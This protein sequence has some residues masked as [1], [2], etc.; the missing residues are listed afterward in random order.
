MNL[1]L[2]ILAVGG[3]IALAIFL[4]NTIADTIDNVK[5]WLE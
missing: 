1:T 4:L 5:E 3:A 2:A